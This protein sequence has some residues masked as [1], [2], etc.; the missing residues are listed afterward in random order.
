MSSVSKVAPPRGLRVTVTVEELDP[1]KPDERQ[2]SKD[3]W[4]SVGGLFKKLMIS[5][6]FVNLR[7][8]F[9]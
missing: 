6:G 1:P 9:W 3:F 5:L 4:A 2:N 8:L 7:Q